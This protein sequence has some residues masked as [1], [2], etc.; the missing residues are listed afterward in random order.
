[1]TVRDMLE[2]KTPKQLADDE[3]NVNWSVLFAALQRG[4]GLGIYGDFLFSE[5]DM[6]MRDFTSALVG[7]AFSQLNPLFDIITSARKSALE[8]DGPEAEAVLYK[9]ERFAEDNTP[10]VNMWMIKPVLD[11]FIFYSMREALSPGVLRRMERS[12]DRR[13]VQEYFISPTEIESL[14]PEEKLPYAVK[15]ITE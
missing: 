4:G 7:P 1:M 11:W 3:G 5:Y 9:L 6:R 13:G 15:Q 14:G 10:F 2:G 12:M 8:E